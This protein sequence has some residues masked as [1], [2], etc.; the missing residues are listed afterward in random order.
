ML[1]GDSTNYDYDDHYWLYI[2]IYIYIYTHI[3]L[4][5][6]ELLSSIDVINQ[7][8]GMAD[9][10]SGERAERAKPQPSAAVGPKGVVAVGGAQGAR[11]GVKIRCDDAD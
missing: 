10:R 6:H 8:L 7:Q 1:L 2:R 11:V 9:H 4:I 3:V 5:H